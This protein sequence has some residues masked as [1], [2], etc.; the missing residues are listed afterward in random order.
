MRPLRSTIVPEAHRRAAGGDEPRAVN[1]VDVWRVSARCDGK[2]K[3]A[4]DNA[5]GK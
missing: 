4:G 3:G 2:R 1:G 5:G